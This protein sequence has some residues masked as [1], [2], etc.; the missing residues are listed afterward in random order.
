MLELLIGLTVATLLIIGWA[1]GSIFA[2]VFL[3]LC[4][5]LLMLASASIHLEA[6]MTAGFLIAA[7]AWAPYA[8]RKG[9][10]S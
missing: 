1:S 3:T 6:G 9:R 2:S 7:V 10:V 4:G 8:L 5:L